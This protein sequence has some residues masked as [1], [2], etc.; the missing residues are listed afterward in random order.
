VCIAQGF[1]SV[2]F[3]VDEDLSRPDGVVRCR[4]LS[5][6]EMLT[7]GYRAARIIRALLSLPLEF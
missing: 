6:S 7:L 4:E 1:P 3:V 5:T 2:P